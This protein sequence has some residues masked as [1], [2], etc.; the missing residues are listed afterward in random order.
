MGPL[1]LSG[2]VVGVRLAGQAQPLNG[3]AGEQL[4]VRERLKMGQKLDFCLIP[5]KTGRVL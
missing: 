2:A 1:V 4:G 5:A 3:L